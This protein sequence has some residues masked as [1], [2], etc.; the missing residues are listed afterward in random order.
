[1]ARIIRRQQ[2]RED[3][4]DIYEYLAEQAG[5][6]RADAF[7]V[8]VEQRLQSIAAHLYASRSRDDLR[9]GLRSVVIGR[10]VAFFLPIDDGIELVRLLYGGR[11]LPSI[12]GDDETA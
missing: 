7:V 5:E 11:D 10:Y 4:F 12:F 3:L 9:T 1:M 8:R 6:I 2:A